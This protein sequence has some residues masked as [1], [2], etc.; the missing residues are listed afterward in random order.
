[1]K[2]LNWMEAKLKPMLAYPAARPFD[3]PD[4][5][6]EPKFDGTRCLAFVGERLRLQNR[7]LVDITRRYPE[8]G[9]IRQRVRA[10]EAIIDGEIVVLRGGKP[11]FNLIQTREQTEG[12]ADFLS[13]IYPASFAC[14]DLIYLNGEPLIDSPLA[15]RKKRLAEILDEGEEIFLVRHVTENGTLLFSRMTEEGW[16]GIM[17]KRAESRYQLGK[18]SRDWLKIKRTRTMDCVILGYTP[19]EGWREDYLGALVIGA[20][21]HGKL[22]FLGK[23]GTGFSEPI[24]RELKRKLDGIRGPKPVEAE[25]PYEVRWVKPELVCEVKYLEITKDRKLRAPSFV[26]LKDKDPRECE[27]LDDN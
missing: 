26:R 9:G 20:Y 3:S 1:M 14:F 23:V 8:L 16:E 2:G 17:A 12:K 7:R 18:R 24:L 27:L 22:T 4:W 10:R 25:P 15:E 11:D 21:E 13:K 19:G 6:F 5:V